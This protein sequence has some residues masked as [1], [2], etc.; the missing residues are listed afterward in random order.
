MKFTFDTNSAN[1]EQDRILIEV[2]VPDSWEE[3]YENRRDEFMD[4]VIG[5]LVVHGRDLEWWHAV[6]KHEKDP[7]FPHPGGHCPSFDLFRD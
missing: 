7:S 1:K 6:M 4:K 2:T 5:V 3:I